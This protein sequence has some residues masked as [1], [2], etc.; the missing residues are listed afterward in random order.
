MEWSIL[1]LCNNQTLKGLAN[2]IQTGS[3]AL[4]NDD[5][6]KLLGIYARSHRKDGKPYLAEALHPDTGSFEGHDGYNHS[7]HYFHSGFCDLVITGI[8]GLIPREDDDLELHPLAPNQWEYFAIDHLIYRGHRISIAWDKFGSRYKLGKG[9]HV[10]VNGKRV[11]QSDDLKPLRVKDLFPLASKMVP[12]E[13]LDG[14][15][16]KNFV[17]NNDGTYYPRV[18]ASYTAPGSSL[19]KVNDGN[20]WYMRHPPNRW[21]CT[22]SPNKE[23]WIEI[24]FGMPRRI[25]S[26]KFYLL[27]DANT[28]DR[29]A[30]PKSIRVQHWTENQWRDLHTASAEIPIV[31]HKPYSVTFA[32]TEIQKLRVLFQHAEGS[33]TGATEIEAWGKVELPIVQPPPPAGNLAFNDGSR[34]YPKAT[35]SF[36]DRFGGVPKM[37]IDGRTNFLPTPLNR[38]TSYESPNERDWFE[39]DFGKPTE[40]RRIELAIYDDRGGVQ[41]P[42]KYTVEIWQK[43]GW[44]AIDHAVYTPIK[45]LGSQWN[46]VEFSPVTA[47][48]LRI[49]F[50]NHGRARSGT[51]EIMV[52]N[53]E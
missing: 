33:Y 41:A 31:G 29:I 22:D 26:V 45:P 10:L 3:K 27:D 39:I 44:V 2:A 47:E 34:A 49:Q 35:A 24:D 20:Y 8:V 42:E 38:W 28:G 53:N 52:W 6:V 17:V 15:V 32:T 36:H 50:T 18:T 1:A 5:Y 23:D 51:S 11:A 12:G 21:T 48:K 14:L 46:T 40:F 25:H 19:A 37:A 4:T 9:L 30:P 16:E 13:P 7:E 43:E